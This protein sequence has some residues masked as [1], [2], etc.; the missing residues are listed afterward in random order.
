MTMFAYADRVSQAGSYNFAMSTASLGGSAVPGYRTFAAAT[1][2]GDLGDNALVPLLIVKDEFNWVT[3]TG[4]WSSGTNGLTNITVG[5]SVGSISA[6]D[7]PVFSIALNNLVLY[8]ELMRR[9]H[10]A[11]YEE[12][13]TSVSI[14]WEHAG[15][16]VIVDNA[17]PVSVEISD[18][19]LTEAFNCEILAVGAGT[20][21]VTSAGGV[22]TING[23]TSIV[24]PRWKKA[25]VYQVTTGAIYIAV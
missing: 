8:D 24:I 7:T 16:L 14:T 23:G 5:S 22:S 18:L 19:A 15:A 4:V 3:A 6:F 17:S 10:F 20:V 11:F 25:S 1:S 9:Y 2:A 12:L 21:T 13:G